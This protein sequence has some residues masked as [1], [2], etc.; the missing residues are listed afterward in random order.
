MVRRSPFVRVQ[1]AEMREYSGKWSGDAFRTVV[2]HVDCC[3]KGAT[4]LEVTRF[5]GSGW[6]VFP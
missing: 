5:E 3:E 6:S 1:V 2:M 4:I